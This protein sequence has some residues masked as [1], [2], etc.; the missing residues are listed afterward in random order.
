MYT[1]VSLIRV[2]PGLRAFFL[3]TKSQAIAPSYCET[4]FP[5]ILDFPHTPY[6]PF[7]NLGGQ[8]VI[9]HYVEHFYVP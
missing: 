8:F 6:S 2:V 9:N 1:E 3:P 7:T 4:A 5:G